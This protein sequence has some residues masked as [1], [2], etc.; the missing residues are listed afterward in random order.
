MSYTLSGV[1]NAECGVN[2]KLLSAILGSLRRL[3]HRIFETDAPIQTI[4]RNGTK[5]IAGDRRRHHQTGENR[6]Q[7]LDIYVHA[8]DY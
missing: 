7:Q 2:I 6:T 1:K 5:F 4:A 3:Y 8:K